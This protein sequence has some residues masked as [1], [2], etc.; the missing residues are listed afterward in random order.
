MKKI[1]FKRVK[2]QAGVTILEFIAFIGLAALV[3]AGALGLYSTANTGASNQSYVEGVTGIVTSVRQ[4]AAG[5]SAPAD[6]LLSQVQTPKGWTLN[7]DTMTHTKTGATVSMA[8]AATVAEG[9]TLTFGGNSDDAQAARKAL[10]GKDLGG[11]AATSA[12]S[13]QI[14]W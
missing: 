7:G 1:T 8:N 3:I 14:R 9:F 10:V 2:L 5:N 11:G 6:L 12:T 13:Q 4:L